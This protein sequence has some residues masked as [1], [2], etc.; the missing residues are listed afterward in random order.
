MWNFLRRRLDELV[1]IAFLS[2]VLILTI[3]RPPVFATA[4]GLTLARV[5]LWGA[6]ILLAALLAGAHSSRRIRSAL[7]FVLQIGPIV[8][9]VLGYT[10]LR[11]LHA[12]DID[13]WL[14][15]LPK[16]HQMM[17]ADTVLFG[18][19]PYLWLA[20]WGLDGHP[21]QRIMAGFYAFYPFTPVIAVSWFLL[22]GDRA[23]FQLIRRTVLISLYCG[24]C[25]YI[26]I[27]VAGPLAL[28]TPKPLFIQSTTTY[29]FLMNNFRYIYDCF[30]SLHTANPWL[31]VWLCRGKL[32]GLTMAAAVLVC[33]AITLST[34][35]LR[36]HYGVDILAGFV[37]AWLMSVAGRATLPQ[38]S[39]DA[40][41]E[42]RTLELA[43]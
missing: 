7:A 36:M 31:M 4:G 34:I 14:G 23:Q 25:C 18:Q 12:E 20:Q 2:L 13:A 39:P 16:D 32:P 17:A 33:T 43:S 29:A 42:G 21:F 6:G 9:A 24:Y 38:Q 37:W 40:V 41:A 30:P 3:L 22:K 35:A 5:V 8:V 26:L 11:L 10:S 1:T 27:P 19:T 28:T 15:I